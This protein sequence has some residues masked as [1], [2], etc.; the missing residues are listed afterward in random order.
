M[1]AHILLEYSSDGPPPSAVDRRMRDLG[2]SRDGAFYVLEAADGEEM[3][4]RIDRLH[5]ALRGSGARYTITAG[6]RG[7]E[8]YEEIDLEPLLGPGDSDRDEEVEEIS[9]LLRA[10]PRSF[11]DLLEAM[12]IGE[13]ELEE[14]LE[15]MVSRGLVT[16]HRDDDG[17]SYHLAGPMLRS[18][19]R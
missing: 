1:M 19:A 11:N 7:T 15:S 8:A 2:L 17:I 18:M 12:D 5:E 16:A 13:E 14:A 9:S 10:E 4:E 3:R 6:A